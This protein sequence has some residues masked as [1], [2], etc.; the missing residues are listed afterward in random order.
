VVA[1]VD[2]QRLDVDL[3][4]LAQRGGALGRAG[5]ERSHHG[6]DAGAGVRDQVLEHDW[7]RRTCT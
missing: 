1:R 4:E 2:L 7:C 3:G 6:L 5:V